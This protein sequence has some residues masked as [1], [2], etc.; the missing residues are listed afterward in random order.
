MSLFVPFMPA[1]SS[2]LFFLAF[3]GLGQNHPRPSSKLETHFPIIKTI[4]IILN[5]C[6]R[7]GKRQNESNKQS[8]TGNAT[9]PLNS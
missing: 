4:K 6:K 8:P 5:I 7:P 1:Y 3:L 9:P 2:L